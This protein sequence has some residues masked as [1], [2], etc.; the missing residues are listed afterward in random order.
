MF[1]FVLES[2]HKYASMISSPASLYALLVVGK[3]KY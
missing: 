3:T 2:S 1:K